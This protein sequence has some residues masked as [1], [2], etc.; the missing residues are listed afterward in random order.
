MKKVLIFLLVIG[1]LMV[2]TCVMEGILDRP[3]EHT[4]FTDE[5]SQD[6]FD[7]YNP[8]PCGGGHGGDGSG[9]IPG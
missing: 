5:P 8:A 3:S 6:V 7:S 2:G 1:I 4:E 9:P